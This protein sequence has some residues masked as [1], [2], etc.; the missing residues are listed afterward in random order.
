[1]RAS[2]APSQARAPQPVTTTAVATRWARPH[3]HPTPTTH[4]H[5]DA[6]CRAEEALIAPEPLPGLVPQ[7]VDAVV[8]EHAMDDAAHVRASQRGVLDV[9][10]D[11]GGPVG[12]SEPHVRDA[13]GVTWGGGMGRPSHE[14]GAQIHT[15]RTESCGAEARTS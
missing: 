4:L 12:Q 14:S 5:H 6:G 10:T 15:R 13:R 7:V 2:N 3:A 1:V 11:V 9:Q 8:T